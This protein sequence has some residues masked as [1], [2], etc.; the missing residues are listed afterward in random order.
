[1]GTVYKETFTKPLPAGAKIIVRKGQ[2]L[3][4]CLGLRLVPDPDAVPPSPTPEN[5]ARPMLA[6]RKGQRMAKSP[7]GKTGNNV[8]EGVC[9]SIRFCPWQTRRPTDERDAHQYRR[10]TPGGSNVAASPVAGDG[11]QCQT[12]RPEGQGSVT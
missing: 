7:T 9:A 11:S 6:K 1:M 5:L 4:E 8:Y 10:E 2:R 12:I 3:A